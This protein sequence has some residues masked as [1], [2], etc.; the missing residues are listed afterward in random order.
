MIDIKSYSELWLKHF[1]TA[2][3]QRSPQRLQ[4][5]NSS[6]RLE[7]YEKW[8]NCTNSFM[9]VTIAN[10]LVTMPV[11]WYEKK[12]HFSTRGEKAITETMKP[13]LNKSKIFSFA[14][15][16][17]YSQVYSKDRD[18][19]HLCICHQTE[20][21]RVPSNVRPSTRLLY[22]VS[23]I[24]KQIKDHDYPYWNSSIPTRV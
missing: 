6:L 18:M 24:N 20:E 2:G 13:N 8:N 1:S 15:V 3:H 14:S 4:D 23:I 5:Y 12:W 10:E 11:R 16:E 22:K 21:F 19:T 17:L 7:T 9:S